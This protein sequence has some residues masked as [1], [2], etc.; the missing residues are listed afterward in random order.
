MNFLPNSSYVTYAIESALL[1]PRFSVRLVGEKLSQYAVANG[2]SV[3]NFGAGDRLRAAGPRIADATLAYDYARRPDLIDRY[4]EYGR[5]RYREDV[6][7]NVT[8]LSAAV[9]AEDAGIFQR[10]VAWLKV[11]LVCRGVASDD[12]AESLRCMA[13]ALQND[14]PGDNSTGA[15]YLQIAMEQFSA[16]PTAVAS[17]LVSANKAHTIAR[18]CLTGLLRLDAAAARETLDDAIAAGMPLARIYT[19]I[20]PPLMREIGRLWQMNEISVAHEH[21][22]SAAVQSILSGYYDRMF[23]VARR[24]ERS[25]LVACVEGEQHEIGARTIADLFELNGWR[26]GFLGANLPPRDLVMLITQ[27]RR[28]PDLI[29]LSATMPAH[30]A[31]LAS[32]IAA[33]RDSSNIPIIV[34]GYLFQASRNLAA[35]LGVDG[36]VS[37][38]GEALAIA[39][40]LVGVKR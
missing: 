19:E 27:A 31:K 32:T 29:A 23:G 10:Y 24:S 5:T 22:C 15:S 4:G 38:A 34:G 9:D 6:L 35:K 36:G 7:Y 21:Y 40:A 28:K 33:I 12:I 16:M 11:V 30:I 13:S 25:V 3:L 17:F 1:Q 39:E 14:A 18:Q 26:T 37:E 2:H 20:L 8:E